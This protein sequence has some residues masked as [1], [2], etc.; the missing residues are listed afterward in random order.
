MLGVNQD[1]VL[2]LMESDGR[3][4]DIL[5]DLPANRCQGTGAVDGRGAA[6]TFLEE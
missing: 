1:V 3:V 2:V 4:D 6:I 5:K